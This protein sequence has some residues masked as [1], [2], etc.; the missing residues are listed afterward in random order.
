LGGKTVVEEHQRRQYTQRALLGLRPLLLLL[1]THDQL[2]Q[3]V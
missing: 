2:T 3:I 1:I